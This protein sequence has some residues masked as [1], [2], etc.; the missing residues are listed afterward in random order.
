MKKNN[1]SPTQTIF[2]GVLFVAVLIAVHWAYFE[3]C[4]NR[5]MPIF[6]S[7]IA[8]I[9]VILL[10]CWALAETAKLIKRILKL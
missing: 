3:Y 9:V 4:V 1:K 10:D 8:T 6:L 7:S 2:L 5:E